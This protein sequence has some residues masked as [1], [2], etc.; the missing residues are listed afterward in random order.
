MQPPSRTESTRVAVFDLGSAAQALP[1]RQSNGTPEHGQNFE[2]LNYINT[3]TE[4]YG[5]DGNVTPDATCSAAVR[6]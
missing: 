5:I 2:S 4:Q 6:G 1:I 3:C